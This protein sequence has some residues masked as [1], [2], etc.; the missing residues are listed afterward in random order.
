MNYVSINTIFS[1]VIR[2]FGYSTINEIDVIEWIGE[3]L[4]FMKVS[5]FY[6]ETIAFVLVK[7]HQ[8][9]IP[10]YLHQIIQ[11]AKNNAYH[12]DTEKFC[13]TDIKQ[14]LETESNQLIDGV[15]L[16]CNGSPLT[17]DYNV[18]YYRP[19]FD[20]QWEYNLWNNSRL[21]KTCF[22]PVRLTTNSFFNN[23]LVMNEDFDFKSVK[24]EYNIIANK[25]LRFSF[26]DGQVAIAYKRPL[27]DKE[28]GM[29][30]IP[31]N[32][33]VITAITY[34]VSFKM[35]T[36]EFA[37]NREGSKSKMDNFES[38]WQ[39]YCKQAIN[40][41]LMPK[42]IDEHQNLL[43][44]RTKLLPDMKRYYKFFGN[45][46]DINLNNDYLDIKRKKISEQNKNI[47]S[48]DVIVNN[49][50]TIENNWDST[51]W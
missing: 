35:A 2:D 49:N 4:D 29:P 34:Y 3:A 7:N 11:I 5:S 47:E 17:G 22:T 14:E 28:T 36:R 50:N 6:E 51:D 12:I 30:L 43:E 44:Q 10:N 16:D 42:G 19:Y 33:S 45:L 40:D 48:S 27:I 21:R 26:K 41:D 37:N 18:A 9:K 32:I 1:K 24:D 46:A 25:Y 8:C 23:G 38:Q 15:I 20:L 39:W 31:D 13:V